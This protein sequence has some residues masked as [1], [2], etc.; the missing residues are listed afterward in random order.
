MSE[1]EVSVVVPFLDAR[2]FLEESIAS[3]RT[4]TCSS[5]ELLLIDDG[6]TDGGT[7]IARDH[8]GREPERV[9]YLEHPGHARRGASAARNLGI[10]GPHSPAH[11]RAGARARGAWYAA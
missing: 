9:R 11:A 10:R 6:S 1:P 7:D 5:W 8:A 3:V 4:Q 2:A